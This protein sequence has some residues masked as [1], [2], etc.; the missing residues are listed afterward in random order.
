MSKKIKTEAEHRY[1]STGVKFWRHEDS[2]DSYF[3]GK[4]H[5]I[6][7]THISPEGKCNLN[8][9][10][11]SV[12]K[13]L[14]NF[15]I[16]L[17]DIQDYIHKLCTRG[18]K[19]V[20]I[21]GGGEP[22]IYPEFN[23]L[24]EWIK[25]DMGLSVALITNG[26]LSHNV[27]VWDA[28]S[29]VRISINNF[30]NW[31]RKIFVPKTKI[32]KDCI[33]GA[34]LI[35]VGQSE[36]YFKE[37]AKWAKNM[38]IKYIRV[39]PDCLWEQEQLIEEHNK[40]ENLLVKIDDDLFFHQYKIH[41]APNSTICHQAYFRPYLSE[42]DGGTIYPCDSIVLNDR[43]EHFD[44]KYQICKATDILN[45][46]DG[47]IEMKF[48]PIDICQGCVFTE[49]IEMLDEWKRTGINGNNYFRELEHEE[50]V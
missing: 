43:A 13:R 47:K 6:I 19:A 2:M 18:L 49:N 50:F 17:C 48:S 7:T 30:N 36:E 45:F 39:L 32:A 37:V 24:V 31:K 10:Y 46:L 25:Y 1:T 40:I 23:E 26:T 11:C 12:K 4:G 3:R 34:S 16:A 42:I 44:K 9:S 15:N 14:R 33:L 8:C 29:W 20:I 5:S 21:T 35:Y 41:G 27:K 38:G 22:T 28:F